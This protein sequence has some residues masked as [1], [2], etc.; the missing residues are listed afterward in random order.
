MFSSF[1]FNHFR[2]TP[3]PSFQPKAILLAAARFPMNFSSSFDYLTFYELLAA[4]LKMRVNKTKP[5]VV[6][7]LPKTN[8]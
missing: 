2:Q 7:I 5:S 8:Q 6:G 1:L 4:M 3:S